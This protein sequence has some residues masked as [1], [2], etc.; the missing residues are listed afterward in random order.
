MFL[1]P[2]ADLS[3]FEV[4]SAQELWMTSSNKEVLAITALDGQA[5]GSGKPGPVFRKMYRLYQEY[6]ATVMRNER[7]E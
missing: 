2:V 5:V 3:P 6:K 4:R 7:G 1:S